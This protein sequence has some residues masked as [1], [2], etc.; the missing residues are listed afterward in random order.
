MHVGSIWYPTC[1]DL[2][3]IG[4]IKDVTLFFFQVSLDQPWMVLKYLKPGTLLCYYVDY[5][6][7]HL[8]I[9]YKPATKTLLGV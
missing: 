1:A 6:G 4:W 2:H 5:V 8:Y 7:L 9:V 3:L